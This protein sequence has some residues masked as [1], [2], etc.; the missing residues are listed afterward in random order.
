M[1]DEV[2]CAPLTQGELITF[3]GLIRELEVEIR[4][5]RKDMRDITKSAK[6]LEDKVDGLLAMKNKVWGGATVAAGIA[7][8]IIGWLGSKIPF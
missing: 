8:I 4:N 3:A 2:P 6:E 5:I 1:T 7:G